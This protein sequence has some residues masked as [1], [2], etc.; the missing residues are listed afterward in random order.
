MENQTTDGNLITEDN[1]Y[2]ANQKLAYK[3]LQNKDYFKTLIEEGYFTDYVNKLIMA[4]LNPENTEYRTRAVIMEKLVGIA[5]LRDYINTVEALS[6]SGEDYEETVTK[7]EADERVYTEKLALAYNTAAQDPDFK[8]L[9]EDC[10]GSDFSRNQTSLITNATII[11]SGKRTEVL[12]AL[13]GVSTLDNFLVGIKQDYVDL[14]EHETE[15][16]EE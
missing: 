12:E 9:I 8:F 16:D 3:N 13:A 14:L 2:W 4:L 11:N 15:E 10:Y 7:Q 5:G 1:S 6:S